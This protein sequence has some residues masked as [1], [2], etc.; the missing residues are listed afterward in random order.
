M[1]IC[2]FDVWQVDLSPTIGSEQKGRRPC[3][4]LQT[5]AVSNYGLTTIIA[6]LTSRKVD[7][8]YPFEVEIQPTSKNG[9]REL[10]KI[11]FDQIRVIDKK[12]LIKKF[13]KIEKEHFIRIIKAV[14][15]IF[16]LD[17]DFQFE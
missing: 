4:V 3:V 5:N 14:K 15:I 2:Q 8:I 12:R 9:L 17:S 16:D 6:P 1:N 10:S 13:G 7:K 11:K